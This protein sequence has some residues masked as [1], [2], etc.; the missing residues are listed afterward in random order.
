MLILRLDGATTLVASR[1]PYCTTPPH[2]LPPLLPLLQPNSG[3]GR[4]PEYGGWGGL[5]KRIER[6][7]IKRAPLWSACPLS[8]KMCWRAAIRRAAYGVV[9]GRDGTSAAPSVR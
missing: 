5:G 8:M 4:R 1:Q 9:R 2:S 6:D 7:G 3:A